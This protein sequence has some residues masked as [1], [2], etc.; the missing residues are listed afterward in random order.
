MPAETANAT[1]AAHDATVLIQNNVGALSAALEEAVR[2]EKAGRAVDQVERLRSKVQK[3]RAQLA[4][5]EQA[6]AD[7][8]GAV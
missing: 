1:A 8:E 3:Q 6:L 4:A 2:R 5:A 7:A